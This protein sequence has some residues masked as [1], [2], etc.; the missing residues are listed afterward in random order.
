MACQ[1]CD[2]EKEEIVERFPNLV[3]DLLSEHG[4]WYADEE[5]ADNDQ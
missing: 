4:H 1:R 3:F 2:E 5:A